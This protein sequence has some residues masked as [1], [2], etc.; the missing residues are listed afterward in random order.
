MTRDCSGPLGY[1]WDMG[2]IPDG[3]LHN[4]LWAWNVEYFRTLQAQ[5][6]VPPWLALWFATANPG[7][8][9]DPQ[10]FPLP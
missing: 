10:Q 5:A 2:L 8:D 6:P 4:V 9:L 3:T 1:I 7:Q